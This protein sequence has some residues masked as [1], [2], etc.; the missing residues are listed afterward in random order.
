MTG[1]SGTVPLSNVTAGNVI[2]LIAVANGTGITTTGI[3]AGGCT[4]TQLGSA[5]AGVVNTPYSVSF[6]A[7]TITATGTQ[8]ATVSFSGTVSANTYAAAWEF[9]SSVGT[10]FYDTSA[11]LDSAGT[12][13]GP[14]LTAAGNGELYAFFSDDSGAASAGSTSG[15]VY[16]VDSPD[17]NG[18]CYNLA[19]S[20]APPIWGDSGHVFGGAVLLKEQ[21]GNTPAGL[22]TGT[23]SSAGTITSPYITYSGPNYPAVAVSVAASGAGYWSN[24]F[25]AEG[26][27]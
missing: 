11:R 13:A 19:Y 5:I 10:W 15:Y 16:G 3:T 26:P 9:H 7:G 27:P 1:T 18:Y 14:T 4:W 21:S 17:A 22:A 20:G 8:T 23:G 24:P 12:N 6:W 2:A 25:L